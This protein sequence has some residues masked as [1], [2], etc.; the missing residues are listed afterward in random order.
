MIVKEFRENLHIWLHI[1]LVYLLVISC[2]ISAP[3]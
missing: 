1:S 3:H 2:Y